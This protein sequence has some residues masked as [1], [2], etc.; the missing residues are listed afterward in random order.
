[1]IIVI[2]PAI[3]LLVF[4]TLS[5]A[6]VESVEFPWNSFPRH[7]WERELAWLKNIGIR[8]VSLPQAPASDPEQLAEL[9]RTVRRLDLEADLEGPVPDAL[10]PL[11]KAHG[12]PLTGPLPANAVRVSALAPDALM[13]SRR[14]LTAGAP[15]L[16]WTD[17]E[18]T[19]NAF[20]N[21]AGAVNFAGVESAAT[22]PLRRNAQLSRYWG[23]TLASLKEMPVVQP[24]PGISVRQFTS[25]K[26]VSFVAI[27]NSTARP[28]TGDVKLKRTVIPNVTVP[29]RDSA[30]LPVNV[31]LLAG[32]LCKDCTAFAT[33]NRLIY[34]TAEL[35][36]M[37][38]ENG[39]LAMEFF[40]PGQAQ[41]VLQLSREPAGPLVA[42]GKPGAVDWDE[43]TQQVKLPVPQ[44]TAADHH[45]RIALA[46]EMPDST[47]FFSSA[48]V[49]LIGET[50]HLT[51]EFSSEA[52]AQRSRLRTTPELAYTQDPT[53]EPLEFVYNIKV[54]ETAI[55]GDHADLS[56]EADGA[57][58]SH[59]RPQ[60]L[61]P[62]TL[63]FTDAI[64]V[65]LAANSMLALSPAVVPV[66]Q[67]AGR[68]VT[69]SIR[70]N[71]PEIRSFQLEI[72]AEGLD[73]SPA[74]TDVTVGASAWRE[75]SFRVF[76]TG[77]ATGL[78]T[79]AAK[80]TGAAAA[81]EPVQFLVI[82]PTGAVAWSAD[83]FFFL[84]SLKERAALQPGRW[85][86]FLNKDNGQNALPAGGSVFG[87]GAIETRGDALAVG[88]KTF[89]LQDLEQMAS[90][91]KR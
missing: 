46:I 78:H 33:T 86:E 2:R 87:A 71:A 39:I 77:A 61:H 74:R 82:P 6:W 68:D 88:H 40:A 89:R 26:G 31:P 11:T 45:V 37:E 4:A 44:G 34:A 83:G 35:T 59:A 38:Y 43:K 80:L 53:K 64:A 5:P 28:W 20:G 72:K 24:L 81:T 15:A 32:P 22:V 48:R 73:F 51:A 76:A 3:L 30:W 36:T 67:R 55:H 29:A 14:F 47:A 41:V 10:L 79:G 69:V 18:E 42:G 16:I 56:I 27:A 17:V 19:L 50:N 84:E 75:V 60:I 66:N 58:M 90:K 1:M 25:V 21:H 62:A 70:N 23:D 65:R 9:I 85:L 8:H 49:L 63:R 7:L 13:R 57:R 12:G 54:P 52:I 91:T